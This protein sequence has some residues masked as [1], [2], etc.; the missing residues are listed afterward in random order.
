MRKRKLVKLDT[1]S[2][3]DILTSCRHCQYQKLSSA[4]P[5]YISHPR[6]R[7]ASCLFRLLHVL[8]VFRCNRTIYVRAI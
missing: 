6:I 3:L 1:V 7:E 4:Y 2:F 5:K 8:P